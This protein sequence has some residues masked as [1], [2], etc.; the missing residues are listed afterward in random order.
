MPC[1]IANGVQPKNQI[2]RC[3]SPKMPMVAAVGRIQVLE[4]RAKAGSVWVAS[5]ASTTLARRPNLRGFSNW[6]QPYP[7][8]DSE[9]P[10]SNGV[11]LGELAEHL[12]GD[13]RVG[14]V[15]R[16]GARASNPH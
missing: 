16:R 14:L 6:T 11:R 3:G 4:K 2:T 5:A 10:P 15:A 13:D 8:P 1:W 12:N 9:A 7:S